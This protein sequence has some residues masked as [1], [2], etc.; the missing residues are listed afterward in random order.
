MSLI[1]CCPACGTMFKVVA[2]QLKISEGWVR[3]GHCAQVFDAPAHMVQPVG[4]A[5]PTAT[6]VPPAPSRAPQVAAPPP[7]YRAP[8]PTLA[9]APFH[10]EPEPEPSDTAPSELPSVAPEAVEVEEIPVF[11]AQDLKQAEA[12]AA[13]AD[14]ALQ[15]VSFIR[16]ARRRAFWSR[17][18]VRA[19]LVFAILAL[20]AVLALQV[21]VQER[22]R[23]AMM[24]PGLKPLLEQACAQ[25]QCT[26][27]P[28]RQ[29]ETIA[30]DSSSFNKLRADTY[31]LNFTLKSSAA[32]PIAAPSMELTLTD[33]QEQPVVR[34]VLS[35]QDL[36]A[37]SPLLPA[38][39][40]WSTT[41]TLSV[42]ATGGSGRIAGYRLLAF[43]P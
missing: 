32:I 4:S 41:V 33:T 1:T 15:E 28:P 10:V 30:I 42:A 2:D 18:F 38:G 9:P 16:D 8:P 25:L 7:E 23:L 35:P 3:C 17:P 22:D 24:Q 36:G 13:E 12:D 21:A 29:I 34:R 27:S 5:R 20:G 31:R 40:E 37:S 6:P 39:G 11:G 26:I 14:A 19:M 43:Y